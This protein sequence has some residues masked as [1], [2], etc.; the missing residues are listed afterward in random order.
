MFSEYLLSDNFEKSGDGGFS[1]R[2]GPDGGGCLVLFAVLGSML[3]AGISGLI[4]AI[5]F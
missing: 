1:S 2:G 4:T 5:V 3:A